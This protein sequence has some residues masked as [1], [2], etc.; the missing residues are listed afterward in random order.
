MDIALLG[1]SGSGKGS[2]ATQLATRFDLLHVVSGELFR[3][4]LEQRTAVG[5]LARRYMAQGELVPDE[6][7]DAMMEEW[8]WQIAP[9]QGVL[10]DG[11]PRTVAQAQFLDDLFPTM[12]RKLA[13][14]IYLHVSDTEILR[15]L[16][17]RL[18]CHTC[19]TP[20]HLQL[21][22]PA[23]SGICDRCGGE[24]E[25]RPD[26]IPE[27][28]RVR[29]RAFQRVNGPLLD[30]YQATG[31][32]I[33]VDGEGALEQVQAALEMVIDAVRRQQARPATRTE[34]DQL[35]TGTVA[36]PARGAEQRAA[37]G[38]NLVLLGGPGSG[39]GTQAEELHAQFALT[40]IATGDL[41]REHLRAETDLGKLA[42][43]YMDRGELVPDD[44]TEAM[45][46]ER[47]T[48]PDTRAG[49]VLDG[50]PRTL[51][52][53]E[54]LSDILAQLHRQLTCVLYINV[55][56]Q[57]IVTR[58][59]GRR[60]CRS[61]QAPYHLRFKP[62]AQAGICDRCGGALYQRDDDTPQTIRARLKTFHAQTAPLIHSY[63]AA[64]LLIEIDGCGEVAAVKQR[65]LA[66][67]RSLR[68][69]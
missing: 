63:K 7:T 19:Q 51:P 66:A 40:H 58:L 2:H 49:F 50:F 30:Y 52:Q 68:H 46:E 34:T 61:C 32:F 9:Q 31:R 15:R 41:F 14:A 42:R 21:H 48:R 67:A 62:P 3:A 39:K 55:A 24:L 29:L 20:Y 1:P 22:P 54:A 25:R 47:L 37:G 26:D 33:R 10:F 69:A 23:R 12:G 65:T 38:L 8:L 16:A 6:V 28:I 35:Q 13:A 56:D 60:I 11:F 4:N 53:A 27:L 43:T 18:I 36:V 5:L 44:L 17:G 45:V 59:G 64:G 57:E